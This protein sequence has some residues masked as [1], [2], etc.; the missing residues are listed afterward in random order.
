MT[1]AQKF[2]IR[3]TSRGVP[4]TAA[5]TQAKENA[6]APFLFQVL[7]GSTNILAAD[8]C[9][10]TQTGIDIRRTAPPG[11]TQGTVPEGFV[12]VQLWN[13]CTNAVPIQAYGQLTSVT[14]DLT[15]NALSAR[16]T[17][18]AVLTNNAEARTLQ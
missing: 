18:E 7:N 15:P 9:M 10:N 8:G 13:W 11:A 14:F 2:R 12:F 3:D 6:A 17:G 5:Q 1:L 16:A 4:Q